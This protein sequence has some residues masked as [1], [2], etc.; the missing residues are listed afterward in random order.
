[1]LNSQPAEQRGHRQR[2]ERQQ[3]EYQRKGQNL[4]AADRSQRAADDDDGDHDRQA[5]HKVYDEQHHEPAY[6]NIAG[7]HGQTEQQLVVARLE[8][9]RFGEK[10]AADEH[11][12]EVHHHGH[13]VHEPVK[14]NCVEGR[15]KHVEHMP[16]AEARRAEGIDHQKREAD[17]RAFSLLALLRRRA[18]EPFAQ[19]CHAHTKQSFKHCRH[20]PVRGTHPQAR[21]RP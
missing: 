2:E 3:R 10:H 20:P 14:P 15:G 13:R 18:G 7:L 9:L 19:G 12:S 8:K 16:Y 1:M 21:S 5:E 6:Q 17:H 11:Q 4:I